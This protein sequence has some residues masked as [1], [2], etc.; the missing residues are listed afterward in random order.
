[1]DNTNN[2][3]IETEKEEKVFMTIS[4]AIGVLNT[5]QEALL[6]SL[7][8]GQKPNPEDL[9]FTLKGVINKLKSLT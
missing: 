9:Y 2:I 6:Y 1:M 4:E 8:V 7:E 3:S 5:T